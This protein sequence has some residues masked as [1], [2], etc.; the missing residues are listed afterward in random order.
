MKANQRLFLILLQV[1][2][3]G[4]TI[5][6]QKHNG[7]L[8]FG[9]LLNHLFLRKFAELEVLENKWSPIFFRKRGFIY[10]VKLEDRKTVVIFEARPEIPGP[11]VR[12]SPEDTEGF[13]DEGPDTTAAP[14]AMVKGTIYGTAGD[15]RKFMSLTRL[16]EHTAFYQAL[17][18]YYRT[19][20]PGF[21]RINS[22]VKFRY[23]KANVFHLT[24]YSSKKMPP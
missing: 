23:A 9:A 5:L 18:P 16:V 22:A 20:F 11:Q 12:G 17:S 2:K 4:F 3:L 24:A 1:T 15:G 10:V 8:L 19:P 6:I 14:V 21:Q 7:N 13:D